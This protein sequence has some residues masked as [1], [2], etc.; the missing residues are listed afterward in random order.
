M[1]LS[2]TY[3][4]VFDTKNFS[5]YKHKLRVGMKDSSIKSINWAGAPSALRTINFVKILNFVKQLCLYFN[6]VVNLIEDF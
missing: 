2:F 6:E 4:L 3:K 1:A 5:S